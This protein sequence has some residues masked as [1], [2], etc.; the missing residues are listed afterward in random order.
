MSEHPP[1]HHAI[2]AAVVVALIAFAF[3]QRTA[4]VI[5]GAVLCLGAAFF[6][7]VLFL[8]VTGAV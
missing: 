7:C 1:H 4:R 6:A 5:V 2:G 8:V 3:G